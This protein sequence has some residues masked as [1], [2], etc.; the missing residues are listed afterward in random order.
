MTSKRIGLD[1]LGLFTFDTT[2]RVHLINKNFSQIVKIRAL[3]LLISCY[4]LSKK[5]SEKV[6]S[7]QL[8]QTDVNNLRIGGS[9]GG[10][11]PSH[12]YS[13]E[14]HT[15]LATEMLDLGEVLPR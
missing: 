1:V 8:S 9:L 12:V 4:N 15:V 14:I 13:D 3:R 7:V 11:A 2:V 5:S 6:G 10:D